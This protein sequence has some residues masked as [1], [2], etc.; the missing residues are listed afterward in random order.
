MSEV[1]SSDLP[2]KTRIKEAIDKKTV[3]VTMF[4][5]VLLILYFSAISPDLDIIVLILTNI[6]LFLLSMGIIWSIIAL[7]FD[8]IAWKELLKGSNIIVSYWKAFKVFM[9][10]WTFNLLLPSAG[11]SEI[12]VRTALAKSEFEN[13]NLEQDLSPGI[14]LPSIILHRLLG[15]LAFIPL[16]IFVAFGLTSID[17]FGLDESVGLTFLIIVSF[18]YLFL[19]TIVVLIAAK[20]TVVAISANFLF[21]RVE[22][23]R[24]VIDQNI[25]T[26][27][28]QFQ[29]L[30]KSKISSL[31]AFAATFSA[32]VSHWISIYF[33]ISSIG[34]GQGVEQFKIFHTVAVISFIGGTIEMIPVTFAGMEALLAIANTSF[35][36]VIP[37]RTAEHALVVAF[38][39]R[40]I[41]FYLIVFLGILMFAAR[42]KKGENK[43]SETL[44]ENLVDSQMNSI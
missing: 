5:I 32:A 22:K 20:P 40:L 14:V 39:I 33:I 4:A 36:S 38:L 2:V 10:S 30:A 13:E 31:I 11:A 44:E 34:V 16:S 24:L 1:L 26:F 12:A 21:K 42:R 25:W 43:N 41:K 37:P 8:S 28:H 18:V 35:Y 19:T 27:S 17:Y 15:M 29:E 9:S 3:I 6:D 23:V 7:L